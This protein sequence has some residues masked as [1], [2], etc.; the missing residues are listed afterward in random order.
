MYVRAE[1]RRRRIAQVLLEHVTAEARAMGY[2]KHI[3]STAEMH[4]SL[5]N[6]DKSTGRLFATHRF[7][8][9]ERTGMRRSAYSLCYYARCAR[10]LLVALVVAVSRAA[11]MD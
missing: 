11:R 2:A 7:S 8:S 9:A 1:F 6:A 4:T 3:L 10:S 5:S